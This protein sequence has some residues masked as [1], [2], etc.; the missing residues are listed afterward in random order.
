[1][2]CASSPNPAR[3]VRFDEPCNHSSADAAKAASGTR[4]L[5]ATGNGPAEEPPVPDLRLMI[6]R[7]FRSIASLSGMGDTEGDTFVASSF[8][9]L[10]G[11]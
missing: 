1:M 8:A 3:D 6:P 9:S 11:Q 5:G 2:A 7:R 4:V 10:R